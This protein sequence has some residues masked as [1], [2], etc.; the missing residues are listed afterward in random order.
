MTQSPNRS[1]SA[2][3]DAA[4]FNFPFL[5]F[6]T[7]SPAAL[8]SAIPRVVQKKIS[9]FVHAGRTVE[10]PCKHDDS[11][12][13][14]FLWYRQH[15]GTGLTLMGTS[16]GSSPPDYEKGFE[17][18]YEVV[19]HQGNLSSTLKIV[20]PTAEDT[21]VY[22]CAASKAHP[23]PHPNVKQSCKIQGL[24]KEEWHCSPSVRAQ[25]L[26]TSASA[27]YF[28]TGTKLYVSEEGLNISDPN[29]TLFS[30]SPEEIRE[31]RKATLVCLAT[32]F[33]PDHVKVT[34][35]M[36]DVAKTEGVGTDENPTRDEHTRKFSISSR[37]RLSLSDWF[38]PRNTFQCNVQVFH[39]EKKQNEEMF[40]QKITG[41]EGCGLSPGSYQQSGNVGKFL[42]LLLVCKSA[43]CAAVLTGLAFSKAHI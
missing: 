38:N 36:N 8:S 29:V 3:E 39:S 2:E 37:L 11:S 21:A 28:G 13:I 1:L 30:P 18:G 16:V 35:T 32:G 4:V 17:S 27:Q 5:L 15:H 9:E 10:I 25:S 42:Y 31:K 24:R 20:K 43:L 23:P 34:W 6:F 14:T 7:S 19:T 26:C 22:F 40:T 41:R 33:Y 12:Y